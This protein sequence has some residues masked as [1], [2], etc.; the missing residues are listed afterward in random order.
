MA[1][2]ISKGDLKKITS[3]ITFKPGA[4]RGVRWSEGSRG[5]KATTRAW[6]RKLKEMAATK[7]K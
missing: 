2:K 6:E 5:A 3:N 1:S 4:A 7:E